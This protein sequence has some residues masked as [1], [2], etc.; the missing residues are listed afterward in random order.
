METIRKTVKGLEAIFQTREL[1]RAFERLGFSV[2][3]IAIEGSWR[4]GNQIVRLDRNIVGSPRKKFEIAAGVHVSPTIDSVVEIKGVREE[5]DDSCLYPSIPDIAE[6]STDVSRYGEGPRILLDES[7]HD[8]FSTTNG[9]GGSVSD[10]YDEP[11]EGSP[12]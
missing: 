2:E 9:N 5:P 10:R 4:I 8:D 12:V 11:A 1:I 3:E 7:D 6:Q